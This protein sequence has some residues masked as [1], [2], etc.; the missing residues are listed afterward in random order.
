[1]QR[2]VAKGGHCLAV[3]HPGCTSTSLTT[4]VTMRAWRSYCVNSTAV[5]S[6]RNR[7]LGRIH[8]AE[9]NVAQQPDRTRLQQGRGR[10][11]RSGSS[12]AL[13]NRAQKDG[14]QSQG[15]EKWNGTL[16]QGTGDGA[17][18]FIGVGEIKK[19]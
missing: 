2:I 18:P 17:V 3:C 6:L 10:T 15:I 9:S 7:H 14:G 8:S 11:H 1:M 4:P 12:E 16:P 19:R 5:P 13:N